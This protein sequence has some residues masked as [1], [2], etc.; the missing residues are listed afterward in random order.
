MY[1]K[2]LNEFLQKKRSSIYSAQKHFILFCVQIPQIM[3][4]FQEVINFCC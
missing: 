3:R 2:R 4:K 1:S